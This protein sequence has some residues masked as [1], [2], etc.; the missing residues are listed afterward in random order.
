[1]FPAVGLMMPLPFLHSLYSANL[2]GCTFSHGRRAQGQGCRLKSLKAQK[3]KKDAGVK[4]I[5]LQLI[6]D[7]SAL[8]APAIFKNIHKSHIFLR[9]MAFLFMFLYARLKHKPCLHEFVFEPPVSL[10]VPFKLGGS[11]A[12]NFICKQACAE[13]SNF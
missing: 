10:K 8:R 12:R 13:I 4:S 5:C 9:K 2:T 11:Q 1:M 3:N 6:P 7:C